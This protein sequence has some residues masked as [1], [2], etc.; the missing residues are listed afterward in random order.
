MICKHDVGVF[1]RSDWESTERDHRPP[2]SSGTESKKELYNTCMFICLIQ[3]I[4]RYI[5]YPG[6]MNQYTWISTFSLHSCYLY[7]ITLF[8]DSSLPSNAPMS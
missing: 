6:D 1:L 3:W 7:K 2:F 4:K 5:S 8:V